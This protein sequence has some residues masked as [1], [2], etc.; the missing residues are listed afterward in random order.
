M[1]RLKHA[2]CVQGA[3]TLGVGS[4][5][6]HTHPL[7][8]SDRFNIEV[9]LLKAQRYQQKPLKFT[10]SY[11]KLNHLPAI[12]KVNF[13]K[14]LCEASIAED[15]ELA[16]VEA[17]PEYVVKPPAEAALVI[18][19]VPV[20]GWAEAEAEGWRA[21]VVELELP[22]E[23]GVQVEVK[24]F[25]ETT[26]AVP[27]GAAALAEGV[28]SDWNDEVAGRRF[29]DGLGLVSVED[30]PASSISAKLPNG[31]AIRFKEEPEVLQFSGLARIGGKSR[32]GKYS[33]V[34]AASLIASLNGQSLIAFCIGV[35]GL[36]RQVVLR[37]IGQ[38]LDNGFA[39][40]LNRSERLDL[41]STSSSDSD[42]DARMLHKVTW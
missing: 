25:P 24:A 4:S 21:K 20:I 15:E 16:A 39:L 36:R 30:I 6:P 13:D 32:S 3:G 29:G 27:M 18:E 17:G 35:R 11:H 2:I 8:V 9:G 33:Y 42:S 38:R 41:L 40:P 26:A 12:S 22:A 37:A 5:E 23:G 28:G 1:R 19:V 14:L 7:A 34:D 31:E 10:S